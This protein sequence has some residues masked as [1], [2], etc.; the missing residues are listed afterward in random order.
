MGKLFFYEE[1]GF[2]E[3][4]FKILD[5]ASFYIVMQCRCD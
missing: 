2:C 5:L 4:T 3:L 1:E